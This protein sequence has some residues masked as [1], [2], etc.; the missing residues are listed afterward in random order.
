MKRILFLTISLG[1]SGVSDK[2]EAPNSRPSIVI[3]VSEQER[4]KFFIGSG[5]NSVRGGLSFKRNCIQQGP[6]MLPGNSKASSTKFYF[7]SIT[8]QDDLFRQ[9]DSDASAKINVAK[10]STIGGRNDSFE[11]F[12][13]DARK[14]YA[15]VVGERKWHVEELKEFIPD[16][17]ILAH[18]KDN[19]HEFFGICG[20]EFIAGVARAAKVYGILEC[21]STS[22]SHKKI[23]DREISAGSSNPNAAISSVSLKSKL[24]KIHKVSKN[25]CTMFVSKRG[26]NGKIDQ[27]FEKFVKSMS[28]YLD[29]ATYEDSYLEYIYTERYNSVFHPEMKDFVRGLDLDFDFIKSLMNMKLTT[30]DLLV[31][32]YFEELKMLKVAK[33]IRDEQLQ[34]EIEQK[35]DNILN[36]LD[37]L[38]REWEKCVDAPNIPENC[39]VEPGGDII[40]E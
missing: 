34:L 27:D 29:D 25:M 5:Y 31:K 16:P 2:T 11:E 19:P 13:I 24:T 37:D 36:H 28:D 7:K 35:M 22:N 33:I 39:G 17:I 6:T 9:M 4:E 40:E 15:F 1:C 30:I 32:Q 26:G 23:I 20:D 38:Y 8:S 3:E 18:L 21:S 10:M 14:S 12:H